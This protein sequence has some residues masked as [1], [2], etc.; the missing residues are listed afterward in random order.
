MTH[1][2]VITRDYTRA[3]ENGSAS[4]YY[5]LY[6]QMMGDDVL[7]LQMLNQTCTFP[8]EENCQG[9]GPAGIMAGW[10]FQSPL[11]QSGNKPV[12]RTQYLSILCVTDGDVHVINVTKFK[13]YRNILF[14]YIKTTFSMR[15]VLILFLFLSGKS[16]KN[17]L[18]NSIDMKNFLVDIIQTCHLSFI[19][20]KLLL[21]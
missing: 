16:L 8:L 12:K 3:V 13:K 7:F 19:P 14:F 9:F 5:P 18:K 6:L 1:W 21:L 2:L 20:V 11:T 4:L 10:C 17:C 15:E